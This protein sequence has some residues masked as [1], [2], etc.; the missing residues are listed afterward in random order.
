MK[1]IVLV[2]ALCLLSVQFILAQATHATA[3]KPIGYINKVPIYAE[4]DN[5]KA[6][7]TKQSPKIY[8]KGG[9][10]LADVVIKDNED[11]YSEDIKSK[12]GFHTGLTAEFPI[13]EIVSIEPGLFFKAKGIKN[14]VSESYQGVSYKTST[15]AN[16]NYL[17][18]PVVAKASHKMGNLTAYGSLGPYLGFGLS[19]RSKME[20]TYNGET[21]STD[22]K[23]KWGSGS[24]D[25]LKRLDYG[26]TAGAGIEVNNIQIGL[27]YDL[28]LANI[29]ADTNN[30]MQ[31][32]VRCF[33]IT[34]GLR[35]K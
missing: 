13:N 34:L 21:Q 3:S 35:I 23:I 6:Q 17:D 30:G 25:D 11:N 14:E 29:S 18:I 19:G 20:E 26:L 31:T 28:G 22:E 8:L 4:N 9:L 2:S 7:V 27:S 32:K 33:N 12:L 5:P 15:N 1:K 16:L 10:N 24:D